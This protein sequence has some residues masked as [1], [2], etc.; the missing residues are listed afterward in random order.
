MAQVVHKFGA[1]PV[2]ILFFRR[3]ENG[4]GVIRRSEPCCIIAFEKLAHIS[5]RMRTLLDENRKLLHEFLSSRDD[6]DYHWPEYGTIVFPRLRRGNAQQFCEL[7][8]TQF[9]TSVVPGSFFECPDHFRIGVGASTETVRESL[10]QLR[11]GL[12]R[13]TDMTTATGASV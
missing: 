11:K 7:L 4:R 5:A 9:E 1:H 13:F 6:L 3:A 12:D 10:E 8:R 2:A